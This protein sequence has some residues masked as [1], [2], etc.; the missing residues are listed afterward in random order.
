M[1]IKKYLSIVVGIVGLVSVV[2]LDS[3]LFICL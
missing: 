3:Y 2:V 1:N